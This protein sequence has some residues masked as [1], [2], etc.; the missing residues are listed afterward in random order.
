MNIVLI[1]LI[2]KIDKTKYCTCLIYAKYMIY[3]GLHT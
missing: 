2:H 3:N 1:I